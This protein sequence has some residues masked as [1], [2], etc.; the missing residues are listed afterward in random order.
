MA[1]VNMWKC[2]VISTFNAILNNKKDAF[3][4]FEKASIDIIIEGRGIEYPDAKRTYELEDDK[5]KITKV[6]WKVY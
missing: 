5:R 3:L 6:Y 2:F 1:S 4:E